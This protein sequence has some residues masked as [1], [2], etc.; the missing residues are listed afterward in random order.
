MMYDSFTSA[1]IQIFFYL[2]FLITGSHIEFNSIL[3]LH[4]RLLLPNICE[5]HLGV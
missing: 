2:A 4:S 1:H 5:I 3:G